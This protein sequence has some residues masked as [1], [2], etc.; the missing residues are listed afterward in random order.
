M[1][2]KKEIAL[3]QIFFIFIAPIALLATR[4]VP[5]EYRMLVLCTS[6]LLI[7]GI[8]RYEKLSDRELG[9][10]RFSYGAVF[11][12]LF[13]TSIGILGLWYIG[14]IFGLTRV[15]QWWEV[16]HLFFPFIPVSLL[17]EI[18]YRSFLFPKLRQLFSSTPLIIFLN[19]ILFGIL[20]SIYP[21]PLL[22]VGV[23][24]VGGLGFALLYNRY[25][26]LWLVS[27]SHIVLNFMAIYLGFFSFTKMTL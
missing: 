14:H 7:I 13:F 9:I 20:H 12:Y 21:S 16:Q 22:M 17:Q 11:W 23:S 18:A 2:N 19:A 4:I 10:R 1:T 27:A 25:P 5:M 3:I 6:L 24:T 8:I 26:N 15:L